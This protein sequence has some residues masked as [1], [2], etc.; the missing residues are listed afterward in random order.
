[1]VDE[2]QL[3]KREK[4]DKKLKQNNEDSDSLSLESKKDAARNQVLGKQSKR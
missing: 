2:K 3:G 1:L 4:N